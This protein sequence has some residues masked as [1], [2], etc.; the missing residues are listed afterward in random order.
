MKKSLLFSASLLLAASSMSAAVPEGSFY[1]IGLN[2]ETEQT[3][4]NH[5][6][7]GERDEED[8]DEG[9]WRWSIASV[10]VTEA[11]GAL[12]I[13]GPEGFTLGFNAENVF[14]ITNNLTNTQSMIYLTAGG[15][16]VNYDLKPG[17]Y[18]V[19]M[20][21]FEDLDGDMGGDN[22]IL[23]LKS[24][25]AEDDDES[26]YLI[27]FNG[28]EEASAVSRFVKNVE[29]ADGETTV[30]YVLPKYYI[31]TCEA[32]FT[33]LD[34]GNGVSYGLDPIMGASTPEVTD[35]APMAFL[36][37]DGEAVKCSLTPGYYNVTFMPMGAMNMIS[38]L[39]SDNQTPNNELEYYLVGLNGENALV[40]GNKF[41]RKVETMEYE[42][43]ETGETVSSE[44]ITYTLTAEVKEGCEL[45]VVSADETV[46]YGY[47][48]DMASFIAND[49]NDTMPFTMLVT[50]GEPVK[51]TLTAGTYVFNFLPSEDGTA[52]L[53]AITPEEGDSGAVGEIGVEDAAP[54][55]YDLQGR[56]VEN[57]GK[58]IFIEKR[59]T[60][61]VKVVR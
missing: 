59:G 35:D 5:F 43:E 36:G 39:L 58:G 23:Q 37:A 2:G 42:D 33:V 38:F 30:S 50:N 4:S 28:T 34:S 10:E 29:E 14:G 16:A 27:G 60:K 47:N 40:E 7:L 8:I 52:S 56:R 21:V 55:Y 22:W 6:V 3:E 48:S 61:V 51:C 44:T 12:T 17:E 11:T 57:P 1:L 13:A 53:S 19:T 41:S 24:L 25:S 18:T 46:K 15:P 26:F 31:G 32:G 9:V 54:V 20:A 45:T 49:L